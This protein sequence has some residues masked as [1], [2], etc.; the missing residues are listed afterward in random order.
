MSALPP[1]AD[2]AAHRRHV[3]FVPIADEVHRSK[4]PPKPAVST[5]RLW[6]KG[7]LVKV[8]AACRLS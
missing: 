6:A 1:K 2:I 3:R 5:R 7:G 8:G 4:W